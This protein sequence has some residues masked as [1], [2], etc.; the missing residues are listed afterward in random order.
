MYL[1]KR[2][3]IAFLLEPHDDFP[4]DSNTPTLIAL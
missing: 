2:F 1:L 4:L 3:S